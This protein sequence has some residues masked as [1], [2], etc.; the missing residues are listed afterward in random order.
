MGESLKGRLLV[1]APDL[2]DPNFA[3]TVVLLLAHDDAEGA[4]GVVV[5]R[6]SDVEMVGA[7]RD[8]DRLAAPP[9]FVFVGGPVEP[10]AVI[11]LARTHAD[12]EGVEPV[13]DGAG[14]LD[15]ALAPEDLGAD[16]AS[17]RVF[18]GYSGW[19]PGQLELEITAGGWF[20]VEAR[21]DDP[22]SAEPDDLWS[23][24]LRRQGGL[25]RTAAEDPSLN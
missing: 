14:V 4:L 7:L 20:V 15:L 23:R 2:D 9:A 21:P 13:L 10:T 1:A 16:V 19:A 12:G 5:N 11:G 24:V 17:I 18:A 8:W 6:P 22:F 25:F 3:H